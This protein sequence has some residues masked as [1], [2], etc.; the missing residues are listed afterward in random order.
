MLTQFTFNHEVTEQN[1]LTGVVDGKIQS[2]TISKAVNQLQTGL[3]TL[4]EDHH[5]FCDPEDCMHNTVN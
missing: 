5:L 1:E 2:Q 3:V 4:Y